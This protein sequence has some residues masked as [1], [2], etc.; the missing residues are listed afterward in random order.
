MSFVSRVYSY[1]QASSSDGIECSRSLTR[2]RK[3]E[4][5]STCTVDQTHS[6]ATMTMPGSE[7]QRSHKKRRLEK[8]G[9]KAVKK[10]GQKRG[11]EEAFTESG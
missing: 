7:T 9:E 10:R 8:Q 4:T 2:L 3:V 5:V 6:P 1:N 11:A